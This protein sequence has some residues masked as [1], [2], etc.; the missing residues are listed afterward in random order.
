MY[1]IR[2]YYG[3]QNILRAVVQVARTYGIDTVAEWIEDAQT[4][5]WV[6]SAGITRGQGFY[7]GA[8]EP[9]TYHATAND[10]RLEDLRRYVK[11]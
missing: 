11:F 6:S 9:I 7:L 3:A 2:S 1:A 10:R 5:A 8:P 4:V